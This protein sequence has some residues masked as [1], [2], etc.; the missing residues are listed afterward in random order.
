MVRVIEGFEGE[1]VKLRDIWKEMREC[2]IAEQ[3]AW[4]SRKMQESL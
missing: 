1:I 2:V 3:N 4:K